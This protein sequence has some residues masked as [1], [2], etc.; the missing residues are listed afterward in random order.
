MGSVSSVEHGQ[1]ESYRKEVLRSDHLLL[2]PSISKCEQIL[3]F[4]Y[5]LLSCSNRSFSYLR[6]RSGFRVFNWSASS[7]SWLH[8][9]QI[10]SYSRSCRQRT[11]SYYGPQNVSSRV[12]FLHVDPSSYILSYPNPSSRVETCIHLSGLIRI[13]YLHVLFRREG[14]FSDSTAGGHVCPCDLR[15]AESSAG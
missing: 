2:P 12:D 4:L 6:S 5:R 15:F 14:R 8:V 13:S 9:L 10:R 1:V 11:R 7:S 3:F